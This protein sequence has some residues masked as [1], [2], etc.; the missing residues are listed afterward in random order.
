MYYYITYYYYYLKSIIDLYFKRNTNTNT[1]CADMLEN[2]EESFKEIKIPDSFMSDSSGDLIEISKIIDI[3]QID[4]MYDDLQIIN[5]E[6][7]RKTDI[8]EILHFLVNERN[9]N[10]EYD[11]ISKTYL[12]QENCQ[13]NVDFLNKLILNFTLLKII[14]KKIN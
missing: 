13:N 10:M 11:N 12:I 2:K 9:F 8:D 1:L 5:N 4:K 6:F 14:L 7:D 3:I